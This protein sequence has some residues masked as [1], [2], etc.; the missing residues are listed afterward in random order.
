ML[1]MIIS[2]ANLTFRVLG[3]RSRSLWLFLKKLFHRSSAYIYWWILIQHHTNVGN[4]SILSKLNFQEPRL[5]WLILEKLSNSGCYYKNF[6][7]TPA[8]TFTNRF[9]Q[10]YLYRPGYL[11]WRSH[12]YMPV[13]RYRSSW[14]SCLIVHDI[15]GT[16]ISGMIT[17]CSDNDLQ[18]DL[19]EGICIAYDT[20]F[21]DYMYTCQWSD[22]SPGP[23]VVDC[24]DYR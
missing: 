1:G 18:I 17:I 2:P 6:V 4:D 20:L 13:E 23:L 9:V 19:C 21:K 11:A 10:G 14:T 8:P 16:A 3:S 15:R 22:T 7:I 12:V 24:Q 5:S